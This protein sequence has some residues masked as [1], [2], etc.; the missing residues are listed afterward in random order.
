MLRMKI[1]LFAQLCS[2]ATWDAATHCFLRRLSLSTALILSG[3]LST[4]ESRIARA[5]ELNSGCGCEVLEPSCGVPECDNLYDNN[6]DGCGAPKQPGCHSSLR[7]LTGIG[8][9][10]LD[11]LDRMTDRFENKVNRM[12][13]SRFGSNP[14]CT[15]CSACACEIDSND[16]IQEPSL[17]QTDAITSHTP[18]NLQPI[19]DG[20]GDQPRWGP[21]NQ[22]DTNQESYFYAE[23]PVMMPTEPVLIPPITPK[24]DLSSDPFIDEARSILEKRPEV[25]VAKVDLRFQGSARRRYAARSQ[26]KAVEATLPDRHLSQEVIY[27][28]TLESPNVRSGIYIR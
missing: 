3:G 12:L 19:P 27:A 2:P 13:E 8:E 1:S 24:R 22:G 28:S 18:D 25:H 7:G 20:Y 21:A 16:Y 9:G 15:K 10:L 6:C 17:S 4:V 26:T 23:P 5:Q 14:S 11:R